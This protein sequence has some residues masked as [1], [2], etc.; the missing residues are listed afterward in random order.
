MK[1]ENSPQSFI[2]NI[3]EDGIEINNQHFQFPL[4]FSDVKNQFGDHYE[5]RGEHKL[6]KKMN[7]TFTINNP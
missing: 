7:D 4:D 1:K 3:T 5:Q 2:I 6:T